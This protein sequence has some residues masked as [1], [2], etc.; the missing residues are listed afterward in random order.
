MNCLT[1]LKYSMYVDGELSQ[2]EVRLLEAHLFV[3]PRCRSLVEGLRAEGRLLAQVLQTTEEE[4]AKGLHV[5]RSLLWTVCS[6]VGLV[7][8]LNEAAGWLGQFIPTTADWLNPFHPSTLISLLFSFSMS[9]RNA[10]EGVTMFNTLVTIVGAVILGLSS[11]VILYLLVRRRWSLPA[12]L[13]AGSA[14]V[15]LLPSTGS[16]IDF[17][18]GG[19]VKVA[20]T[21]TV[22]GTLI[23]AGDRVD[24]DGTVNGDLV[25]SARSVN[26]RGTV[27]GSIMCFSQTADIRGNAS[28]NF[29]GFVQALDLAGAVERNMYGW[30]QALQI[31]NSGSVGVDA[32]VGSSNARLRGTVGRD[33]LL[34]TGD[35]QVE[36]GVGRDARAYAGDITFSPPARVGGNLTLLVKGREHVHL[37]PAVSV[38]G[39]TDIQTRKPEPSHYL[40]PKFY[41][42][43]AVKMAAA[44]LTGLLVA[45]LFPPLFR[46]QLAQ[47]GAVAALAGFR[48]GSEGRA[49]LKAAGVGF[50]ALVATP[51]AAVILAVTVIGLPIAVMTLFAWVAGLYLAKVF[52]G[53]FIGQGM[54]KSQAGPPRPF[55]LSLLLGLLIIYVATN[56]PYVG[57]WVTLL[58]ILLGLGIAVTQAHSHWRSTAA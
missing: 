56:L 12:A 39:K 26:V 9:L 36:G 28:G 55:A 8:V 15:L 22:D 50:L 53:A 6:A 49:L 43:E 17:R 19:N 13:L 35:G 46:G 3:C 38:G 11:L 52:V 14:L 40:R 41:F 31:D 20:S 2:D 48:A 23:A 42:W 1:E 25:V 58:V 18:H 4:Q 5:G 24:I 44:L 34:L 51:V 47:P 45:W 10:S 32:V 7:L 21:E 29:Y 57:A 16:A 27:K 30:V 33:L 37:D 54:L